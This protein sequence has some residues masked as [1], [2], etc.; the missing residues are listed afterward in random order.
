MEQKSIG[1][2]PAFHLESAWR[3]ILLTGL[4]A[5]TLDAL[6]PILINKANPKLMFQFIASGAFGS[7]RAFAGGTPMV[8]WGVLFHYFIAYS[9]TTLFFLLYPAIPFLR[10]NKYITAVLYGVFVWI[11]MNRVVIPLSKIQQGPF[12]IKGALTGAAILIVAIGLPVSILARRYYSR[13]G[14]V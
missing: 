9:W 1:S 7:E 11:V 5:G 12:N 6:G 13:K 3:A 2:S 4:I 8:V 14:V 10:K